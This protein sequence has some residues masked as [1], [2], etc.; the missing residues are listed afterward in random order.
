[1]TRTIVSHLLAACLAFAAFPALAQTGDFP[2]R[3][4][5]LVVPWPAGGGT[6]TIG[7]VLAGKLSESM[8]QPVWVDNK[9]G[10]SGILGTDIVAKSPADGYTLIL[11]VS[12]HV[13]SPL[14]R[15]EVPYDPMKDFVPIGVV[16]YTPFMVVSN[17]NLPVKS[18]Q[19]LVA[20][21]KSNPGKV[22]FA[23][24]GHGTSHHLGFQMFLTMAGIE[25]L[26]VPYKGGAPAVNDLLGGQVSVYMDTVNGLEQHV[27]SGKLRALGVSTQKRVPTL[28]DVPTLAESGY[29][30]YELVGYWGVLAPAGTPKAVVDKLNR[31]LNKAVARP[32]TQESLRAMGLIFEVPGPT[33]E[34]FRA[35]LEKQIPKYAKMIKDAGVEKQ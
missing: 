33:S 4:I 15:K 9:P 18:V 1:M 12:S 5:R 14:L 21:A 34:Q 11:I 28:P 2:N 16:G 23:S 26:H 31:E 22:A 8:G 25:M 32:D 24:P 35:F 10:V 19:E 27:K 13:T 6:D 29:P 17:P 30:D 20:H 3:S 7:R